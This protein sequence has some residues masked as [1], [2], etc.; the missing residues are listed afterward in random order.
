[1]RSQ[2]KEIELVRVH[3]FCF[4]LI[5]ISAYYDFSGQRAR[6]GAKGAKMAQYLAEEHLNS[7]GEPDK[8]T[9]V[10]LQKRPRMKKVKRDT[11]PRDNAESSNDSDFVSGSSESDSQ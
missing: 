5:Q 2:K 1:M 11:I 4:N 7:E 8:K 6:R 3:F 10:T 9:C